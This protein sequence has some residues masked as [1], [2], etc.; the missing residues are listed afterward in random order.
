MTKMNLDPHLIFIDTAR[1][2]G[3]LTR[4]P[5]PAHYFQ[6][7][8]G[9][10]R[11]TSRAFPLAGFVSALPA[12]AV[13]YLAHLTAIP[14]L[15]GACLA[16][17]MSIGITGALH[18]DGLADV[19]DGFF[20]GRDK[21]QRLEIMKDSRN[22][23]YGS[24]A[25]ILSIAVRVSA[26]SAIAMVSPWAAALA[27]I[28]SSVAA[29]TVLVWHWIE[30]PSARPGGT[31]DKVGQPD[32]E[33]LSFAIITGASMVLLTTFLAAGLNACVLLLVLVGATAILFVRLC[34]EKIEGHTGDTLGASAQIAEF[35][36]LIAL[37]AAI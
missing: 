8:D 35:A 6:G 12:A 15:L 31:A 4:L 1:A 19:A 13:I 14:P 11:R 17:A 2:L 32:E 18:E 30:L 21:E 27:L 16:I 29:R 5:V 26:L 37:A 10:L 9:S 7:D 23:T 22:G 28:A 20:G 3:F 24:L 34:R 25:L 36:A 33:S